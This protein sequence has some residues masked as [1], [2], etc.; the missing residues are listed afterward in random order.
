M[1]VNIGKYPK[2]VTKERK[3]SIQIDKWDTWN[4]DST[5][6][7]I[8]VPMLKQLKETQHGAPQVELTDVPEHL[9]HERFNENDV[10]DAY[11]ERWQYVLNE[12]IFAFES[13]LTDW[14]EQFWSV[15]PEIDSTPTDDLVLRWKK[16][17]ECNWAEREKY[18]QRITNGFRLFGKYYEGLW[19]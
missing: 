18:Q 9:Q 19:D 17:G 3:I 5:L 12:M 16:L 15:N 2:G 1:K 6:A 14:S 7:L 11:F 13:K 10:D 4:M 8:V